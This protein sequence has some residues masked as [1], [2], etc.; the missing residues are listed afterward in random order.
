ML[1]SALYREVKKTIEVV[2]HGCIILE[3]SI[4]ANDN[5][6]EALTEKGNWWVVEMF[7]FASVHFVI[8]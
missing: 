4:L 7:S 2:M 6:V 5:K 3:C 8:E 1:F